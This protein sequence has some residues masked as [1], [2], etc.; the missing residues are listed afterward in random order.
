VAV[1]ST[2]HNQHVTVLSTYRNPKQV[3]SVKRKNRDSTSSIISCPATF[4]EYNSIMEGADRLD[5]R[6]ERYAI[7]RRILKW[8][9]R[10]LYFIID[11]AIVKS[12]MMWDCNNGGQRDQ[13]S[14]RLALVRQL[15]VGCEIKR[16]D[17]P[18]FLTKNKP[19][20]SGVPDDMR[21]REVGKYL[22]VRT[23]RRRCRQWNTSKHE[24]RTNM[25][26]SH[27][28]VTL[29]VCSPILREIPSKV[30]PKL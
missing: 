26:C 4:A 9:Y 20:V 19:G 25:T 14:F 22:P 29:C 27:C 3:T 10:L 8:G 18:N 13:L 23:T 11:L 21:L 12:F 1:L 17:K 30:T 28:K 5:Q 7:G 15:T 2:Y 24:A 16:R 6:R